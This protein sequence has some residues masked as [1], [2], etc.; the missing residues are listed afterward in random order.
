MN[1]K[2]DTKE[3]FSVIHPLDSAF[4]AIMAAELELKCTSLIQ[5]SQ[6]S[7]VL[8][9][10][11]TTHIQADA[12]PIISSIQEYFYQNNASF[13][14]CCIQSSLEKQLASTEVFSLWNITPTESE[15]ADIVQME[16]IE[17]ELLDSDDMDFEHF[18]SPE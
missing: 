8:N 1:V 16:E 17:R 12:I 10:A 13:V 3:K 15:A 7:I 11:K 18:K 9:L 4:S 14:V 5:L 6:H 2:I